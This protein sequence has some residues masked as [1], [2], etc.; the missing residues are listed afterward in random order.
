MFVGQWESGNNIMSQYAYYY[1]HS[2]MHY[3]LTHTSLT[4]VTALVVK[5][6][7]VHKMNL[8]ILATGQ[9]YMCDILSLKIFFIVSFS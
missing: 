4:F 9:H 1:P 8:A 6:L 2:F 7:I 3:R 5:P